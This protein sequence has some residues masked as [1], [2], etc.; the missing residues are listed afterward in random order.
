MMV[1]EKKALKTTSKRFPLKKK[2]KTRKKS[3][4]CKRRQKGS[5]GNGGG[6]IRQFSQKARLPDLHL[7]MLSWAIL[8]QTGIVYRESG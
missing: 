5:G 6:I 2:K 4:G 3:A 1:P 7:F 8:L